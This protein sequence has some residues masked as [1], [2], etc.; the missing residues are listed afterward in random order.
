MNKGDIYIFSDYAKF[1]TANI[2]YECSVFFFS[3]IK[4]LEICDVIDDAVF[5][6]IDNDDISYV[7][8]MEYMT[9]FLSE[10]KSL[11]R[12]KKLERICSD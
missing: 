6:K 7:K 9:T 12:T 4:R 8:S 11:A 5:V 3:E 1:Y 2:K 10:Q